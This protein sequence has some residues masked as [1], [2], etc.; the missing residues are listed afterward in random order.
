M[1]AVTNLTNDSYKN[2]TAM[3]VRFAVMKRFY[4]SLIEDMNHDKPNITYDWF[5]VRHFL[6]S[7]WLQIF[8]HAVTCAKFC[9]DWF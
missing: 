8:V 2:L 1:D 5:A 6:A 3:E 4:M 9:S 7:Q